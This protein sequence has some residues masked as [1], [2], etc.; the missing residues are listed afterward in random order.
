MRHLQDQAYAK[1]AKA[2]VAP[3]QISAITLTAFDLAGPGGEGIANTYIL[4]SWGATGAQ[5][6]EYNTENTLKFSVQGF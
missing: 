2:N 5:Q 4:M 3:V 1:L 6:T